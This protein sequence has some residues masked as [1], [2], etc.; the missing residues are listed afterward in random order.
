MRSKRERRSVARMPVA[1]ADR[2]VGQSSIS[3]LLTH[4][5]SDPVNGATRKCS[6]SVP[7]S[8]DA[9]RSYTAPYVMVT[10]CSWIG[11]VDDTRENSRRRFSAH[12][13][14]RRWPESAVFHQ[15]VVGSVYAETRKRPRRCDSDSPHRCAHIVIAHEL[16]NSRI[17]IDYVSKGSEWAVSETR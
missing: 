6:G 13:E 3:R 17:R 16:G 8:G 5:A 11:E 10:P 1:P 2:H 12:D 15:V 4:L 7:Q 14:L 9:G